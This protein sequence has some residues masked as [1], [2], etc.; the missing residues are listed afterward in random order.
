MQ[1][2]RQRHVALDAAQEWQAQERAKAQQRLLDM[3]ETGEPTPP[4]EPARTHRRVLAARRDP[5]GLMTEL[6]KRGERVTVR[7]PG[8]PYDFEVE[9][10]R[11]DEAMPGA[12][13]G[14]LWLRGVVVSP[15]GRQQ[16]MAR[17][18]Y[19]QPDGDGYALLPMLKR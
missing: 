1:S 2:N 7:W 17:T 14:W 19:V 13:D 3:A 5:P 9:F 8:G 11:L 15:E 18:F 4:V 12:A 6:P 10:E 16:R